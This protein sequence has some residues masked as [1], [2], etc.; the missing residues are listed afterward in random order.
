MPQDERRVTDERVDRFL[1]MTLDLPEY[2]SIVDAE[3]TQRDATL[4]AQ[5]TRLTRDR[6]RVDITLAADAKQLPCPECGALSPRYDQRPLQTWEHLELFDYRTYLHARPVRVRCAEHGVL[7][8]AMPWARPGSGFTLEYEFRVLDMVKDA[9]VHSVARKLG[10]TDHRLWRVVHHYAATIRREMSFTDIQ[11][12]GIDEKASR[13]GH[14]YISLVV[15]LDSHKVIFATEG[16]DGSVLTEFAQALEAGDGSRDAISM[17][18]MDMSAAYISG[19][20]KEFPQAQ[21]I[22]DKFHVIQLASDAVDQVRRQEQK[23]VAEL[24]GSRYLFLKNPDSLTPKQQAQIQS[25]LHIPLQTARAYGL[26]L[27]LQ[28]FYENETTEEALKL[29]YSRAIRSRLEPMKSVAKTIKRHWDGVLLGA[30]TRLTN[31]VLEGINSVIQA[32][33]SRARGYRRVQNLINM[34][35]ILFYPLDRLLATRYAK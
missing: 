35:F 6:G 25:L 33:K 7:T 32:A 28:E 3:L 4:L 22:F 2:W 27:Q 26:R 21:I 8:V 34:I 15:D 30:M 5:D 24:K 20:E 19:V 12:I 31:A 11:R 17:V 14:K 10:V 18:T 29:W 23:D 1:R 16:R 13:R 9:P